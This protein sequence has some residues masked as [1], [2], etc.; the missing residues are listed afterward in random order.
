MF[1]GYTHLSREKIEEIAENT[2][3]RL[4]KQRENSR[5]KREKLIMQHH[6]TLAKRI[7]SVTV[8]PV[9]RKDQV[10]ISKPEP[11]GFRFTARDSKERVNDILRKHSWLDTVPINRF[12]S[13]P[14]DRER[15]KEIQ[16]DLKFTP[17]SRF[18]RIK[19]TWGS[20]NSIVDT[21]WT[22]GKSKVDPFPCKNPPLYY[23]T[24][25][26][27]ALDSSI[28]FIADRPKAGIMQ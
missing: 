17:R 23:K 10:S 8:D 4:L 2:A 9:A 7:V 18:L 27:L 24:L 13:V 11:R 5:K 12:Q 15:S 28:C 26:T 19:E 21:S 3:N 20:Q 6:K 22:I 1:N 14:R 16:K 25:E